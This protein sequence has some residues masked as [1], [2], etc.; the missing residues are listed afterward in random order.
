MAELGRV[1]RALLAIAREG[2][3]DGALAAR[4][5][6]ACIDGFGLDGASISVLTTTEAREMVY[7]S[8][9]TAA[10]L[11]E[12][13]FSLNEGACME[14]ATSGRPVL[15]T[16][17]QESTE[18]TRWP[19][20]AG[21]VLERTNARALF[22][23]PLQWGAVALGVL[24]LYRAA[25]GGLSHAQWQDALSAADTAAMMLLGAR[26][27]P[28]GNGFGWLD[29]YV[30]DHAEVHQATGMVL[31]QLGVNAQDALSRLRA[32][33]FVEQ[34]LLVEIARDVVARRLTFTEDMT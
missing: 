5:C 10:L 14:A 4:I 3:E 17:L 12:L 29:G 20:F 2:V 13:Q 8:N 6:H 7:A 18:A 34:R 25:P 9:P 15:V 23:L 31:V 21:A 32:H 11:E 27:D 26:T 16:D 19:M 22:A 24:D 33:A 30:G 1:T 28:G